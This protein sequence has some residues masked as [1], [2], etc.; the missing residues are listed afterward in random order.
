MLM[1]SDDDIY[2]ARLRYLGPPGYTLPVQATYGQIGLF[3]SVAA[4]YL[5]IGSMLFTG[6]RF[7]GSALAVAA[8]TTYYIGKHVDADVPVRK[9]LLAFFYDCRRLGP[10]TKP[11]K[12]LTRLSARHITF[13]DTISEDPR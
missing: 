4:T 3:V 10:K 1:R 12:N 2:R 7:I 8:A 6:G 5:L 11:S 13:R 9:V